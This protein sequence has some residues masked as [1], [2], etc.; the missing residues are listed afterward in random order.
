MKLDLKVL[1]Q[2]KPKHM[3]A[4]VSYRLPRDQT[5]DSNF[6]EDS[7]AYDSAKHHEKPDE[8]YTEKQMLQTTQRF[9]SAEQDED[10]CHHPAMKDDASDSPFICD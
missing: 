10:R 6:D 7:P 4:D 5:Y 3:A 9:K 2:P 8:H 1:H